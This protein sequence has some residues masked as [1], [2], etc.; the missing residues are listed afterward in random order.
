[1]LYQGESST[2]LPVRLTD[3]RLT[4]IMESVGVPY[5]FNKP[6]P[7]WFFIGKIVSKAF[8]NNDQQLEWLNTVRVRTREFIAFTNAGN[9]RTNGDQRLQVVEVDFAKPQ[10]GKQLEV[11]WKPARGLITQ[12]VQE[13]KWMMK[14]H[15]SPQHPCRILP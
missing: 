13:C 6:W 2:D 5:D 1:M 11:F 9:E 4:S 14:S 8:F 15:R 10:P 7:F 3:K 12:K